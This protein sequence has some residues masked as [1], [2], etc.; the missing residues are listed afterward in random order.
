[1]ARY[2]QTS[3]PRDTK[4]A[5]Q[6]SVEVA[7]ETSGESSQDPSI[8]GGNKDSAKRDP[9]VANIAGTPVDSEKGRDVTVI[10]WD[11][12]NDPEVGR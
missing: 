8:A 7:G 10:D 6:K 2:G 5:D 1:M 12:P 9:N 11:G 4:E 3:R